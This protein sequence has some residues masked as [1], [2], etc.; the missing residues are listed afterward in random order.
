LD[1]AFYIRL[2]DACFVE[3]SLFDFD[4][5]VVTVKTGG[6]PYGVISRQMITRY[7]SVAIPAVGWGL[8][9]EPIELPDGKRVIFTGLWKDEEAGDGYPGATIRSCTASAIR[10]AVEA[11]LEELAMPL[12]G[13]G[14]KFA[15]KAF[16]GRGLHDAQEL[17]E[18]RGQEAPEIYV[19]VGR[20]P[21]PNAKLSQ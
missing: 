16:M 5:F 6:R 7:P 14:K 1:D 17:I 11:G 20:K 9:S 21:R 15:R 10:Q 12:I 4:A 3:G 8:S 18:R 13:G 19:L 2:V